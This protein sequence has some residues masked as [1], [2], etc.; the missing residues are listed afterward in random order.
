MIQF[1]LLPDVKLEYVRAQRTKH[2]VISAALIVTASTFLIFLM[3]FLTVNVIQKK[4]MRDMTRDVAK[5]SAQLKNTPDLN[6]ILTIQ[7]QLRALPDLHAKKP[8][9]SRTFKFIE[10]ITPAEVALTN[11][12]DD[13]AANTMTITG[14]AA[15]L[16]KVNTFVDTLKYTKFNAQNADT[17]KAFSGVVL[18]Q[19]TRSST[20]TTF[21]IT[22]SY[23][24]ALF[25]N[26]STSVSLT[27]PNQVSTPSVVDQPTTLFK[28][29]I[30]NGAN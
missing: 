20:G 26:A 30:T 21:V 3:L 10:Q 29:A 16:D 25:D 24:P 6:K 19:F 12:V 13:Y 28:K 14:Q 1:N 17:A 2:T 15:G 7:N 27:V 18:T 5:Y 11:F 4:T 9:A 23:N 8:A 22:T